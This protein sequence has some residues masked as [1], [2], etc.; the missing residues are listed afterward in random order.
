L[1]GIPDASDEVRRNKISCEALDEM[2]VAMQLLVQRNI[3][4]RTIYKTSQTPHRFDTQILLRS[5]G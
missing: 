5:Q 4:T 3:R 2:P 1:K